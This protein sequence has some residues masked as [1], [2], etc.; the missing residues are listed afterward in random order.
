MKDIVLVENKEIK[1]INIEEKESLDKIVNDFLNNHKI[2]AVWNGEYF[3]IID[4]EKGEMLKIS[5]PLMDNE[6][7]MK[8]IKKYYE[9]R[10]EILSS[11]SNQ[12]IT[13]SSLDSYSD[14]KISSLVDLTL[15]I[16]PNNGNKLVPSERRFLED[17]LTTLNGKNLIVNDKESNSFIVNGHK[18]YYFDELESELNE[19]INY[20]NTNLFIEKN[21]DNVTTLDM[22]SEFDENKLLKRISKEVAIFVYNK[23]TREYSTYQQENEN[24]LLIN[25]NSNYYSLI[26]SIIEEEIEQKKLGKIK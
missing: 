25:C 17:Y 19:I 12:D 7:L 24:I 20:I 10:K 26:K 11:I 18:V 5:K 21:I 2:Y 22:S 15:C 3:N 1:R 14:Y 16:T 8:V 23:D 9:D 6:I 13:L 4:T